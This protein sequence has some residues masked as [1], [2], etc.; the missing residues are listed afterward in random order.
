MFVLAPILVACPAPDPAASPVA[1]RLSGWRRVFWG[2]LAE[3]GSSHCRLVF[4]VCLSAAGAPQPDAAGPSSEACDLLQE[5]EGDEAMTPS[6]PR[7]T[8]D[9]FA[10]IHRCPEPV[11]LLFC[12]VCPPFQMAPQCVFLS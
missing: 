5:E 10:A 11:S 6:R 4:L 2:G 3:D 9:L 8:E 12:S 7:T 1:R